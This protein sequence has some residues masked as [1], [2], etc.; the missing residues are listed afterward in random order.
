MGGEGPRAV[1]AVLMFAALSVP[2]ESW[3]RAT[4]GSGGSEVRCAR[5]GAMSSQDGNVPRLHGLRRDRRWLD[6][7]W[8]TGRGPGR[9]LDPEE[10]EQTPPCA[11][12][13][14]V[15]VLR[16]IHNV[17]HEAAA[18]LGRV[19]GARWCTLDMQTTST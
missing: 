5:G 16:H 11:S 17:T 7:R 19:K 3:H 14:H 12:T 10:A 9:G 6:G 15:D 1:F 8:L 2:T 4:C 13:K 18:V